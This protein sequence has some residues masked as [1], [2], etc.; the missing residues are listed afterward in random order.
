MTTQTNG[1]KLPG[2]QPGGTRYRQGGPMAWWVWILATVF[3][4]YLFNIQ[5]MFSDVQGI[6]RNI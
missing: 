2:I 3:V 4:I 1:T 6:F 5:T